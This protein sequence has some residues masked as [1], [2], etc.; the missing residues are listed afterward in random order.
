MGQGRN[1]SG[2]V[3]VPTAGANVSL[4]DSAWRVVD[5][6]HDFVIEGAYNPNDPAGGHS[7][8]PRNVSWY[9][10]HFFIPADWQSS[11]IWIYFEGIF[12]I[13]GV[14]LNG[15]L[16][17]VHDCGYTSFA[18]RL[19]N[20]SSLRYGNTT[21]PNLLA[22]YVDGTT[23]SGWFVAVMI[24]FLNQRQFRMWQPTQYGLAR[25]E[26]RGT[27]DLANAQLWSV[28]RPWLYTLVVTVVVNDEPVDAINVTVGMRSTT[29]TA[30]QGLFLNDAHV[31]SRGF[32][33]HNDFEGVGTAVL[34]RINLFRAQAVRGLGG[35]SWR[36]SHNPPA[37]ALLDILDRLGVMVMDE[38]RLFSN[39]S[40]YVANMGDLV[41]RDRNHASVIIWSFCN[42]VGCEGDLETGGP[43]FRNITYYYDGSRAVLANMFTFGDLLSNLLDVQGFSHQDYGKFDQLHTQFPNR[44]S[45]ASECCSCTTM[46]GELVENDTI[47]TLSNFNAPCV[48]SQTNWT[49][50]PDWIVGQMVWTALDYYGE[51]ADNGWP[52]KSSSFGSY[53]LSGKHPPDLT[54]WWLGNISESSAD[55]PPVGASNQTFDFTNGQLRNRDTG[56]CIGGTCDNSSG[57]YPLP[58]RV[59]TENDLFSYNATTKM[60][61]ARSN[62]KCL[63]VYDQTG[64]NVGLWSCSDASNQQWTLNSSSGQILSLQ[65]GNCLSDQA[66]TH[67]FNVYANT[68]KVAVYVDGNFTETIDIPFYGFGSV[69]AAVSHNLTVVAL[70]KAGQGVASYSRLKPGAPTGLRVSLDAPSPVTGTGKALYADG[71]VVP[72]ASNNVTLAILS[73]PG[74]VLAVG[75]GDPR[76]HEPNQATWRSAFH[77]LMRG[78]VQVTTVAVGD[79]DL[80]EFVD[81]DSNR[82]TRVIPMSAPSSQPPIVVQACA[83]GLACATVNIPVSVDPS[84]SVLNAAA[85]STRQ[86]YLL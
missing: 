33:N 56:L 78:I 52:H 24:S 4:D 83:Q 63:D 2:S 41:R 17:H 79:R 19:D 7:Y 49:E 58:L 44:P 73:G 12:R 47:A 20:I 32:C 67:V 43:G 14:F 65:A 60:F 10:K 72:T 81:V 8:L 22:V 51:P 27:V 37:P 35:N 71:Q 46:R 38:N 16:L 26:I 9:R 21:A 3:T 36:M 84:D 11:A 39:S 70:D 69:S 82:R 23:G 18:V 75:N 74:R 6:P 42:E 59:C 48:S 1:V 54:R 28:A 50:A 85:S 77:G 29:W 62:G 15:Q 30:S 76:C 40:I 80:L 66:E 13:S 34:D 86:A 5:L 61:V 45:Y 55:R 68:E 57:C 53:D 31:K 25:V 64:P